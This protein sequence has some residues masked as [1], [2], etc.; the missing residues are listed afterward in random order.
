[1]KRIEVFVQ[2]DKTHAVVSA[3]EKIGVGGITVVNARGRGKG[4]RPM[5]QSDR[6]TGHHVAEYNAIDTIITIV[7]DSKTSEIVSSVAK[8]A[9]TG[10]KGDGKIFVSNIESVTDIGSN[11]TGQSAL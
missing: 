11:A 6:G 4:Q 3:I 5:M 9:S 8:T 2:S 7:D 1:M 10:S